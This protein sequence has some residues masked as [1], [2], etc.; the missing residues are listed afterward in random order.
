MSSKGEGQKE[1]AGPDQDI[2]SHCSESQCY[3]LRD[4]DD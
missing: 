2:T 1:D 4:E 3:Q